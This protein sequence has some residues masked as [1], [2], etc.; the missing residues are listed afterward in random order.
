MSFMSEQ[1]VEAG[2][3]SAP[4]AA[5]YVF[6]LTTR[7]YWKRTVAGEW[8]GL[9]EGALRRDLKKLRGLRDKVN[10]QNGERLSPLDDAI[11]EIEQDRRVDWTGELAG[12]R[13]GI[14]EVNG[15]RVLVTR[16]LQLIQPRQ[17]DWPIIRQIIDTA[18]LPGPDESPD[19]LDQRDLLYTFARDWLR[20][21]HAH[22]ITRGPVMCLA[23]PPGALKTRIATIFKEL[24][25]GKV[26]KVYDY[27]VGREDF[28]RKMLASSLQL[29]DDEMADISKNA[30]EQFAQKGIKQLTANDQLT[31]RAMHK[32][33]VDLDACIRLWVLL[34]N[35]GES[36]L[37][38]PSMD[39]H[40]RDKVVML[41]CRA[42][43]R[44]LPGSPEE[45]AG[46]WPAPMPTRTSE[47]REAFWA[48]VRAELPAF[49]HFLLSEYEVPSWASGS[50]FGVKPWQHPELLHE[51][52]QFSPHVRLW[53]LIE[54]SGVVFEKRVHGD[55]PTKPAETI[56]LNEWGGT[57][58]DLHDLLNSEHSRLSRDD[59]RAIPAPSWIGQRLKAAAAVWGDKVVRLERTG[60]Q[61]LWRLFRRPDLAQ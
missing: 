2:L 1:T 7:L 33:G 61:R 26:S 59:R 29:V 41:L 3:E 38:M 19:T 53:Q 11:R 10:A 18:L 12:F 8:I 39:S 42:K 16:E 23:G 46:C 49:A 6:D 44:P 17:G 58:L 20:S 27:L 9:T 31:V 35:E 34:N 14:H 30:R 37:V 25:G 48:A 54:Q 24:A 60:T 36:L 5:E 50:R 47:E 43:P 45:A 15:V 22:Q 32:D 13:S 55:D 52:Q 57:A 21:L 4:G 51:L 28:N 56:S 40:V